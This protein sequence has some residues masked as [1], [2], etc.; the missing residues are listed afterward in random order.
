MEPFPKLNAFKAWQGALSETFGK[1]D[2]GLSHLA[3]YL[4][5]E[6]DTDAEASGFTYEAFDQGQPCVD[7][8]RCSRD[9]VAFHDQLIYRRLCAWYW[10]G[11]LWDII[12]RWGSGALCA[13]L[14][15]ALVDRGCTH[16]DAQRYREHVFT[17]GEL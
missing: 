1:G 13:A 15:L 11:F 7:L 2:D 3:R 14:A 9:F 4:A 5:V 17:L 6:M 8:R 12:D 10:H 16:W